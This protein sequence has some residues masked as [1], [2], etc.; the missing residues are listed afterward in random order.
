MQSTFTGLIGRESELR[1][2]TEHIQSGKG[3]HIY[4][5]DGTG[6]TSLLL[7][8][9]ANCRYIDSSITPIYCN[10]GRNLRNILLCISGYFLNQFKKLEF[11]DRYCRRYE[12][13]KTH[14]L[15]S[16]NID[17][18][19][20]IIYSCISKHN[21]CIILDHLDNV[22]P[23]IN[24]FLSVLHEKTV[25]ITASRQSWEIRDF[26]CRGNLGYSLYLTP[27]LR[28]ENLG[29]EAAFILMENIYHKSS[30]MVN[31]PQKFFKQVYQLTKGNPGMILDI[32]KLSKSGKYVSDG[33]IALN[34]LLIDREIEKIEKEQ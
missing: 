19:K 8:I 6:K 23:R 26:K 1:I 12:V 11:T 3:I 27:K 13:L 5:S 25:V 15:N 20:K 18:L 33:N 30:I 14:Q 2:L 24:S 10:N 7:W 4:G 22:T 34:L 32:F 16:L 21:L 31:N 29:R 17:I 9:N 28:I